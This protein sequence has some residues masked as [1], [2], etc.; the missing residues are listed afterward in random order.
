MEIQAPP[1]R[2][3]AVLCDVECWP[4]W[5]ASMKS[6]RRLEA[7]PLAVGS[8]ARVAQPK[9][10]PAVWQV[11]EFDPNRSFTW[12]TRSPGVCAAGGHILE[13]HGSG[14]RVT[15]TLQFSGWLGPLMGRLMRGMSERYVAMEAAGLKQRSETGNPAI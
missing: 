14:S 2:V 9:L 7:G 4:E 12:A 6:V 15:L 8:R 5:T 10:L 13:A 1:E 3:W 11:T